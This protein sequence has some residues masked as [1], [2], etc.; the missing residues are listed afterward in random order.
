MSLIIAWVRAYLHFC[1]TYDGMWKYCQSNICQENI[2]SIIF[3][4]T[5]NANNVK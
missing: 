5:E 4:Q 2:F 3:S 1:K